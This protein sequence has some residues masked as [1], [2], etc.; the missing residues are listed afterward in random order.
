MQPLQQIELNNQI[1]MINICGNK[2]IL[3]TE[4]LKITNH[5]YA[6]YENSNERPFGHIKTNLKPQ[7]WVFG[8]LGQHNKLKT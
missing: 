7:N 3:I 6:R 4:S 1:T 8:H 5:R 2:S